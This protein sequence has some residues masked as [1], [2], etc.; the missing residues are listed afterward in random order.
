MRYSGPCLDPWDDDG[1]VEMV[2]DAEYAAWKD[3]RE[4]GG[5]AEP[6]L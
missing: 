6:D 2:A 4:E 5:D 3:E 1:W